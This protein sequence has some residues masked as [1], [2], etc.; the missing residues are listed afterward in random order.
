[1]DRTRRQKINEK[2]G[3]G[4]SKMKPEVIKKLEDA[5]AMDCSVGEACLYADIST[6][7]Y[8]SWIKKDP[9]LLN[10]F[11]ALRHKPFLKAR[12]AIVSNLN[13]PE[14]ALKYM[15]NKKNK[16]FC[17]KQETDFGGNVTINFS[18]KIKE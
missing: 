13:D 14:F 18:E 10:R 8:Y 4:V 11:K 3:K 1:M 15:K 6:V 5:F 9:K 16:E 7:T 12:N 17:E 2:I